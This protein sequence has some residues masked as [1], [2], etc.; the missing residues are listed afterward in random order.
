M[1]EFDLIR[2]LQE[3]ICVE[4]GAGV[5]GCVVGIGD[6]GAVL[7]LPEGQSLV[8]CTDTLVEGVHFPDTALPGSTGHKSLAVNLSDLAAAAAVP[9][10]FLVGAVLP[11]PASRALF[12][13][14]MRGF[15]TA[16]RTW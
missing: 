3:L 14:L 4:P 6:D 9:I 15:A 5:A 16:A 10:G 2:R 12:E 13:G 11:R 7:D 8:V 1:S